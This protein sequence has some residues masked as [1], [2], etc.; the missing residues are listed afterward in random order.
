MITCQFKKDATIDEAVNFL[1]EQA[2]IQNDICRGLYGNVMFYSTD[3]FTT[4][5]ERFYGHYGVNQ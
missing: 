4:A 3:D 5:C 1:H 2:K